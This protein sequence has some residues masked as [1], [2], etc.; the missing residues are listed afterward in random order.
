ML[1]LTSSSIEQLEQGRKKDCLERTHHIRRF[2]DERQRLNKLYF[3]VS[4]ARGTLA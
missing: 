1:M 3:C 2:Q 4:E